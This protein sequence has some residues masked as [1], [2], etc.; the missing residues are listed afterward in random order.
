MSKPLH[1]IERFFIRYNLVT[2]I[3]LAALTLAFIVYLCYNTY[4]T[5]TTPQNTQGQSTLPASFDKDT[6]NK[7]KKLHTPEEATEPA[8]P[9]NVRINPFVE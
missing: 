9:E 5:A 6:A 3:V 4:T 2:F 1:P 7:L 8:L